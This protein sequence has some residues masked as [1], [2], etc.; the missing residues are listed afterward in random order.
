MNGQM[1]SRS[2]R[3]RRRT[4]VPTSVDFP[5]L[6]PADGS[7][8]LKASADD[9]DDGSDDDVKASGSVEWRTVGAGGRATRTPE[10]AESA[11][12]SASTAT[13][14]LPEL[15]SQSMVAASQSMV[16]AQASMFA[17]IAADK[18]AADECAASAMQRGTSAS[19]AL[20]TRT[21]SGGDVGVLPQLVL[22]A[23]TDALGAAA[24]QLSELVQRRD[25]AAQRKAP[26]DEATRR[27]GARTTSLNTSFDNMPAIV[28]MT[29]PAT[30]SPI[31]P[32]AP[33]D[34]ASGVAAAEHR[35]EEA[36]KKKRLADEQRRI[37][38]ESARRRGTAAHPA[39]PA[40]AATAP[41]SSAGAPASLY[42]SSLSQHAMPSPQTYAMPPVQ[43]HAVP[44]SPSQTFADVAAFTSQP[45]H[46]YQQLQQQ[47]QQ[48]Y[49]QQDPFQQQLYG[50]HVQRQRQQQQHYRQQQQQQFASPSHVQQPQQLPMPAAAPTELTYAQ[51]GG[52]GVHAG[53][54][55]SV[56]RMQSSA[57][58]ECC[59]CATLTVCIA[60]RV[61]AD[62]DVQF[63][64][65]TA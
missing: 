39:A 21:T 63:L 28:S 62:A 18:A 40:F 33:P 10:S 34:L 16:A 17:K 9:D 23:S 19:A 6:A 50:Q 25:D 49:Q 5:A 38:D 12:A 22:H 24:S 42:G 4:K 47:Q 59:V 57:Q 3:R 15:F 8:R 29:P 56:A 31:A 60:E 46:Q 61:S 36:R 48:L 37:A 35:L 65:C 2:A 52:G 32:I 7:T 43:P 27:S 26:V 55:G 53:S 54:G 1:E 58:V 11:S 44:A 41:L 30:I 51:S 14:E 20:T 45:Q 13:D 64:G